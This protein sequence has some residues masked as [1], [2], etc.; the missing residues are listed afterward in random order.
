MCRCIRSAVQVMGLRFRVYLAPFATAA[1][2]AYLTKPLSCILYAVTTGDVYNVC[3]C[4]CVCVCVYI[5]IYNVYVLC[6]LLY[7]IYIHIYMCIHIYKYIYIY[8]NATTYIQLSRRL[9]SSLSSCNPLPKCSPLSLLVPFRCVCAREG[10][11]RI[12]D[13]RR[14]NTGPNRTD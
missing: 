10:G 13:G 1:V 2:N 4:V 5:Q 3:V 8:I 9:G 7:I 12:A 6:I 11:G 14:H